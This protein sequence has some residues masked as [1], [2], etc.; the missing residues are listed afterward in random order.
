MRIITALTEYTSVEVVF[1]NYRLIIAVIC[2]VVMVFSPAAAGL[3][4][5]GQA[6]YPEGAA[7]N[8]DSMTVELYI[9][10]T[11]ERVSMTLKEYLCGALLAEALPGYDEE[12]LKALAVAI[13]SYTIRR[14]LLRDK[15]DRS[16]HFSAD[17]CDDY[18]HCGGFINFSDAVRLWGEKN[19][20]MWY[21]VMET[22][23][24]STNSEAVYYGERVANTM[25]HV[26]SDGYTQSAENVWGEYI[27][28][29]VS[30]SSPENAA[31]SS[32][33]ISPDEL[34]QRLFAKGVTCSLSDL[35]SEWIT[36]V[37]RAKN[38][39]VE[40][41]V[42]GGIKMTGVRLAEIVGLDSLS[43]DVEYADGGFLFTVRGKGNGVGM[44]VCGCA[45]MAEKGMKYDEIL[46]HYYRGTELR[47]FDMEE[48]K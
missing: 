3:M 22:A 29:L 39:R 32:I 8:A 46:S 23:V 24:S 36:A 33:F 25:L 9:T 40:Y 4:A 7:K 26:S 14:I 48:I 30:V 6:S 2:I 19:A 5:G 20:E 12:A 35:P 42:F 45:F 18:T 16:K 13:R 10:S 15:G 17:L 38:K 28:Y 21:N 11:G 1:L 47:C 41:V 27:P 43:F 31:V 44:S 34:K 37:K